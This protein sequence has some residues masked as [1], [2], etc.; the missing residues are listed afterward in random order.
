VDVSRYNDGLRGGVVKIRAKISKVDKEIP[1]DF[2][3]SFR[4]DHHFSDRLRL[5]ANEKGK[6]RIRKIDDN[7]AGTVEIVIHLLPGADPD[8]TID[9]LYAFTDCEVPT[10]PNACV[11]R[12]EKPCFI[13]VSEILRESADN[14][15]QLLTLE[16]Q[17]RLDELAEI[18]HYASLERIFIENELYEPIK[19]CKTEE[20]ILETIETGLVPY[21]KKLRRD[22]TREDLVRLSN[23]PIKRISKFSIFKQ[24]SLSGKQRPKWR[25]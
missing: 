18:W 25:R 20:S 16:L 10:S 6:I 17:I 19:L 9:A 1:C 11:I 21:R 22:V 8:V 12:D 24:K 14:T 2:G 5:K 4:T 13:G 23:I 15:V 3:T 7:T